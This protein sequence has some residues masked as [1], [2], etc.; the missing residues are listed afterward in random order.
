[1]S[2]RRRPGPLFWG[3]FSLLAGCLAGAG[4]PLAQAPEKPS[5]VQQKPEIKKKF[6]KKAIK[7]RAKAMPKPK[8][9]PQAKP[10]IK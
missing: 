1:M 8:P 4:M 7:P 10:V 2:R 6:V 9:R 3:G 5:A